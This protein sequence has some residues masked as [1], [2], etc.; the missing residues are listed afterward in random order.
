M[1][2]SIHTFKKF[3][4]T[5]LLF[6]TICNG[7]FAQIINPIL[8]PSEWDDYGTGD[9][10]IMKFNGTYY[11]YCSTRDD[12]TG[13]KCSSSPDLVSWTYAGMCSTDPVTKGAYAPEVHYYN[14]A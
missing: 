2:N 9:P 4:L 11:L 1:K 13:V 7:A 6:F 5:L 10:Y 12:L 3:G 14:G 8:L